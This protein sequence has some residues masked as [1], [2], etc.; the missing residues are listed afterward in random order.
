MKVVYVSTA[1]S[2]GT[3]SHLRTLAPHVAAA[4][5]EVRILCLSEEV[6][7]QF[8]AAGVAATVLP[9]RHKL[10]LLGAARLW[11]QLGAADIVHT[12]DRR[13]GLLARPQARLR[14]AGV[15]HTLHGIPEEIAPEVGRPSAK[16]LAGSSRARVLWL[17]RGY[18]PIESA[19]TSLGMMVT[20]SHALRQFLVDHGFTPARIR[21]IPSAVEIRRIQPA[22]PRTPMTV[23]TIAGLEYWKGVD[24][25]VEACGR[26]SVPLRLE[27]FGDGPW[28]SR[29]EGRA[30]ALGIDARFH[31]RVREAG[32][33]LDS[34][35]LF[36][37]PSRAD[38]LPLAIL[39]AMAA[40][41]PVVA[42]RVGGVPEVVDDGHT[43]ILVEP[44]DT[45]ALAEAIDGLAR[46]PSRR[47]AMGA[48]GALRAA[49]LFDPAT[50]AGRLLDLYVEVCARARRD[51]RVERP[52]RFT[53][54]SGCR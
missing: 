38:N 15:V 29:L 6:A 14:G 3:I 47:V 44:E 37:S 41:V 53:P 8:R 24:L 33:R 28:R 34:L 46:D 18:L 1:S 19:L 27:V 17:R 7:E 22:A 35:D 49:Q 12:H 11:P 16:H 48:A 43:G 54:G 20:P 4:G 10:D 32:V 5:V 50:I 31:G 45:V 39:E 36:V 13:A 40:A 25:L 51:R 30:R 21:V 23:G 9:V 42:T 52:V 2:G 26:I